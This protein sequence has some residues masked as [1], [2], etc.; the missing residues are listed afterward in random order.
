MNGLRK[1]IRTDDPGC[2]IFFNYTLKVL[3]WSYYM[4]FTIAISGV[5]M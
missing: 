2:R 5:M 4:Y 3:L 1:I